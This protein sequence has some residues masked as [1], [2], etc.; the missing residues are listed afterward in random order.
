MS[1]TRHEAVPLYFNTLNI[2]RFDCTA[3]SSNSTKGLLLTTLISGKKACKF[4]QPFIEKKHWQ[5]IIRS[6]V[7][8]CVHNSSTH[9]YVFRTHLWSPSNCANLLQPLCFFFIRNPST[10]LWARRCQYSLLHSTRK[11]LI[12]LYHMNNLCSKLV[13]QSCLRKDSTGIHQGT[14]ASFD[15]Y[16]TNDVQGQRHRRYVGAIVQ[17]GY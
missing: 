10:I 7:S 13:H 14:Q 12:L 3:M 17:A 11:H 8:C 2:Y 16:S 6:T 4:L 1:A 5:L 9:T 15:D